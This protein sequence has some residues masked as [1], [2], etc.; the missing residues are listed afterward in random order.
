MA[1]LSLAQWKNLLNWPPDGLEFLSFGVKYLHEV[2]K[3]IQ[4]CGKYDNREVRGR[5][6]LFLAL[7]T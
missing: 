4:N 6:L 7:V 3:N 1:I 5:N 2:K